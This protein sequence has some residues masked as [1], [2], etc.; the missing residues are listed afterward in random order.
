MGNPS[1]SEEIRKEI[2]YA[3][4]HPRI[5]WSIS[6]KSLKELQDDLNHPHV[7]LDIKELT[8]WDC[9]HWQHCPCA[10]DG[11]NTGGDCLFGK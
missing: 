7:Q 1:K 3:A 11:Y 10:F 4:E 8:C 6:K 2:Q 5:P 9:L